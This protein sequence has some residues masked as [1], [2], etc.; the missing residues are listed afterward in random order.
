MAIDHRV[1]GGEHLPRIA[2]DNRFRTYKTLWDDPGNAELK[3][4]RKIPTILAL[5]DTVH[6]PDRESRVEHDAATGKR[7]TFHVDG[8]MLLLRVVLLFADG[9]PIAST[10]CAMTADQ[11][12]ESATTT[13]GS[14]LV[15]I[16]QLP[17]KSQNSQIKM[18][19]AID[20]A[21]RGTEPQDLWKDTKDV[22]TEIDIFI[23]HLDP[24][25]QLTGQQ[26][27]LNNLGYFAGD[28][29][30]DDD[31]TREAIRLAVEEFQCDNQLEQDGA[32]GAEMSPGTVDAL[33]TVHGC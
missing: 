27:R 11:T 18:T 31:D 2:A 13:E 21:E 12:T 8:D 25:E 9:T 33:R 30:T 23:A 14:G 7:H 22:D 5:G 10:A 1:V 28:V 24:V 19:T 20:L 6:V 32:S 17:V 16:K 4:F 26:A 15:E 3:L 29:G